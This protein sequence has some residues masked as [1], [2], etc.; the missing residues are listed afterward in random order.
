MGIFDRFQ[1]PPEPEP[2]SRARAEFRAAC[3]AFNQGG[4]SLWAS[5]EPNRTF[6][7]PKWKLR[8][9]D[10]RLCF[11]PDLNA[12][13]ES[14]G[15]LSRALPLEF[16]RAQTEA[17]L[18][19]V[20]QV[21]AP[22]AGI[23]TAYDIPDLLLRVSGG[24]VSETVFHIGNTPGSLKTLSNWG[25]SVWPLYGM[26]D[27]PENV[28]AVSLLEDSPL[29]PKASLGYHIWRQE[30][31][32][33]FQRR[34]NTLY[35][36]ARS[37]KLGCLPVSEIESFRLTGEIRTEQRITG[38]QAHLRARELSFGERLLYGTEVRT[39][40]LGEQVEVEQEP[41]RL[42]TIKHD[43]RATELRVNH[44]GIS[45]T[46]RFAADAIP[47]F[48]ALLPEKTAAAEGSPRPEREPTPA[49]QLEILANLVDRGYLTR[50][51]FDEAKPRLLAKL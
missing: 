41:V 31:Q 15:T 4:D 9:A 51:E 45:Y 43:E 26:F 37:L 48:E 5:C 22:D 32:L 20:P 39:G 8:V 50:A 38:G 6:A 13:Q 30:G 19:P 17:A 34:E 35:S 44:G 25:F 10:D 18:L 24:R 16:R 46:L 21:G 40:S 36:R 1:A 3:D 27:C 49:E 12:G 28:Q 47:A 33:F 2:E 23:L 29:L 42:E 11:L 7:F 14:D